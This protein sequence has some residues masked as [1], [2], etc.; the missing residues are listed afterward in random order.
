MR[1]L[2]DNCRT[3]GDSPSSTGGHWKVARNSSVGGSIFCG[4][5][6]VRCGTGREP[7][8]ARLRDFNSRIR[9]PDALGEAWIRMSMLI[10]FQ[11][12]RSSIS[13][14]E[15]GEMR[16]GIGRACQHTRQR[17]S[18][19]LCKPAE[20]LGAIFWQLDQSSLSSFLVCMQCPCQERLFCR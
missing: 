2:R 6:I 5:S 7:K 10:F 15:G 12:E 19:K 1:C 4:S 17:Y 13:E 3:D 20:S 8:S 9:L 18:I 11:P 14:E 16:P